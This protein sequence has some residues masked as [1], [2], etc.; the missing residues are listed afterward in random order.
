MFAD[1]FKLILTLYKN[2]G[3]FHLTSLIAFSNYVLILNMMHRVQTIKSHEISVT[4]QLTVGTLINKD[5][6]SY[7][8]STSSDRATSPTIP[9]RACP[10]ISVY[11]CAEGRCLGGSLSEVRQMCLPLSFLLT[12][13]W[14]WQA[15]HICTY[16]WQH[17]QENTQRALTLTHTQ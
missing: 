7:S 1:P 5:L 12:C 11:D 14:K 9:T 17:V 13:E 8:Q 10:H 4:K 15:A 3:E 6:S 16:T 2:S